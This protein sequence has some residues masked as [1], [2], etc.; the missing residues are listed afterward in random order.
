MGERTFDILRKNSA[1]LKAW[2]SGCCDPSPSVRNAIGALAEIVYARHV[3]GVIVSDTKDEYD[4][5]FTGT[6]RHTVEVKTRLKGEKANFRGKAADVFAQVYFQRS[7][8]TRS[9]VAIR[10]RDGQPLVVN[11]GENPWSVDEDFEPYVVDI[12]AIR[13]E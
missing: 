5:E 7:A 2:A 4:V 11:S 3:G 13:E 10:T 1:N 6:D 9:V 8:G 12:D